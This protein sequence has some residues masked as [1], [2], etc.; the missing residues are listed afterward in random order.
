MLKKENNRL[1]FLLA[2]RLAGEISAEEQ[3]ELDGLLQQ[4]PNASFTEEMIRLNWTDQYPRYPAA[5]DRDLLERHKLR[6]AQAENDQQ[7]NDADTEPLPA[8]GRRSR[9]G[10]WWLAVAASLLTAGFWGWNHWTAA[11][12]ITE[13]ITEYTAQLVTPKGARTRK[14][15]PDGSVVWLNAG[16][17]LD[18]PRQFNG[19]NRVV[20]LS[21]EAYFEVVKDQEHPFLVHTPA[22]SVRVLGTG[23]NVRAYPGEDSAVTA[24]VHGSVEV[25]SGTGN[26]H[27]IRLKPNE[28]LTLPMNPL[29][30][31]T[32]GTLVHKTGKIAQHN[33]SPRPLTVVQDSVQ[34]ETAWVY[35]KLAFRKMRLDELTVIL[36]NWFNADIRFRNPARKNLRFTGVYEEE[37]LELILQTLEATGAFSFKRDKDGVIWID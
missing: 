31:D 20:K 6:L 1:W 30:E 18:Y 36:S 28:K 2:R 11:P 37:G 34:V 33:Q 15:L 24:L 13:Q 9:A 10:W 29:P 25:L 14:T 3:I 32:S 4:Y 16:S 17:T 19:K 22:F 27:G 5:A 26:R 21:G 12:E 23:F 7:T 8:I 35:N